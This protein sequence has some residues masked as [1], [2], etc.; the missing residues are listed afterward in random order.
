MSNEASTP[1]SLFR[2]L[3]G[4]GRLLVL[5]NAWDAGSAR[6]IE[7]CGAAAIATTSAGVAWARG[8]PDGHGLP[9]ATLLSAVEEI[10]R[11]VRV[12]LSVDAEGGYTDDPAAVGELVRR[13]AEAG[14]V[15]INLE[16]GSGSPEL[17]CAKIAAAKRGAEQAGVDVFVNAR[18]D[19]VLRALAP[20]EQAA[21]EIARRAALYRAAGC[22]GV[23][24]PKLVDPAQVRAVVAAVAPLPLN[25]LAMPTLA[26]AEE[27]RALGVRRLSAGSAIAA[28]ALGRV[29]RLTAALLADGRSDSLFGA[30]VDYGMM[31][32]LLA[33]R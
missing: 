19:V 17:L 16:D 20:A 26:P 25:L 15:G 18:V 23:F 24:A 31:N 3:H 14:A 27:L 29:R 4:P 10:A 33:P 28:D 9:T 2:E 1:S 8:Y 7:D 32:G 21:D 13:L 30:P 22:D 6:L 12:P 11:V 5:P